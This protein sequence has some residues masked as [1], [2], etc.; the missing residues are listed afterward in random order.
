MK[1]ESI[2][3]SSILL[4]ILSASPGLAQVSHI[5]TFQNAASG[6]HTSNIS[7]ENTQEDQLLGISLSTDEERRTTYTSTT[8]NGVIREQEHNDTTSAMS[9]A[10]E[11]GHVQRTRKID[12]SLTY[13]FYD[14]GASQTIDLSY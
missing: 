14:Y 2:L 12:H 3:Y 7:S 4:S 13:D 1:I 9:Q 5:I 8:E 10:V 6:R 11:T